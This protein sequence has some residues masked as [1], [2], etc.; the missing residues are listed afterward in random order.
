MSLAWL[1][2]R[3]TTGPSSSRS[4]EPN[5]GFMLSGPEAALFQLIRGEFNMAQRLF[6]VPQRRCPLSST[7]LLVNAPLDAS[8]MA[9]T[10]S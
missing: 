4:P 7:S 6:P 1:L 8:L 10:R 3:Y 9:D 5:I 2:K